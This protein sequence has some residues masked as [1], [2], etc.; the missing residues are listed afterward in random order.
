MKIYVLIVSDMKI[1]NSLLC[2]M[3]NKLTIY[4]FPFM[5]N[6]KMIFKVFGLILLFVIPTSAQES[7]QLINFLAG[8]SL[9]HANSTIMTSDEKVNK[10]KELERLTGL[11]TEQ[12]TQFVN[13]LKNKPDKWIKLNEKV[14]KRIN[15]WDSTFN[16]VPSNVKQ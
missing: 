5:R 12:V 11:N 2:T 14:Q 13:S 4:Y 16:S 8:F 3:K 1:Q 9:L 10:L 15:Y 7:E 6:F